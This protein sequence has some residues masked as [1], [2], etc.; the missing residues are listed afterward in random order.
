MTAQEKAQW[1]AA[2]RS[3]EYQQAHQKLHVE[4]EHRSAY[5]CLGVAQCLFGI[6][7]DD[8]TE[9][10]D[11]WLQCKEQEYLAGLNDGG[12]ED[13]PGLSGSVDFYTIADYI[14]RYVEPQHVPAKEHDDDFV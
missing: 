12:A 1:V 7:S 4:L 10:L 2:L 3:G 6:P 11:G 5:C 14:E 9:L 13:Y 8:D